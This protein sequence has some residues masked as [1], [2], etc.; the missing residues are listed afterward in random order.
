VVAIV[1]PPW[2]LVALP[3]ASPSERG[4][5]KFHSRFGSWSSDPSEIAANTLGLPLQASKGVFLAD[6]YVVNKFYD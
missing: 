5:L 6:I 3:E 4:R 1:P 2:D